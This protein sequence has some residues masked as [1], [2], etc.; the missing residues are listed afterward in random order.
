MTSRA[1]GRLPNAPLAYVLAQVRFQLILEIEKFVPELQSAL[2]KGYPRFRTADQAAIQIGPQGLNVQSLGIGRWE[3]G[4]PSNHHEVI[5][6]NNSLIYHA[7]D[8]STYEEFGQQLFNVMVSVG[9]QIPDMFVE[10]LGLRYIDFII[11]KEPDERPE[12]Y[13][14]DQIHCNP[15][16]G[17]SCSQHTGITMAEYKLD[18]GVLGVRY[19][20][21]MGNP[22]L[23]QDLGPLSLE[24]S[25]VMKRVV[26]ISQ[27]T[28]VLDTDR[29]VDLDASYN[30]EMLSACFSQMH[31]D[32]SKAFKA[33]TTEHAIAVWSR[34]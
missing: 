15:Y 17:V 1:L 30:P 29:I 12:A 13:V 22:G 26:L 18:E 19:S 32:V 5:L 20:R 27:E 28:G 7:T 24:P 10:R 11:P 3:F 9:E 8:Y 14:T 34:E 25:D 16:P 33:L 4:S 6:Q 21:G 2:R 23:P 31:E